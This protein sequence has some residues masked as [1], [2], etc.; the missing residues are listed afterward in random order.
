MDYTGIHMAKEAIQNATNMCV[1]TTNFVAMAN[2]LICANLGLTLNAGKIFRLAVMQEKPKDND[3]FKPYKLNIKE[4]GELINRDGDSLYKDLD[5]ITDELLYKK[6]LIRDI[7]DPESRWSKI[8]LCSRASFDKGDIYIVVNNELKPYLKNLEGFYS[9]Y[10]LDKIMPFS[11]RYGVDLYELIKVG[12]QND[13]LLLPED[14]REII[15]TMDALRIRTE[16][17]ELYPRSN[18]FKKRVIDP[19]VED[20]NAITCGLRIKSVEA[21]KKSRKVIAYKF[22]ITSWTAQNPMNDEIRKKVANKK[23]EIKEKKIRKHKEIKESY[24]Q[25]GL[26]EFI[27]LRG[28]G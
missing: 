10:Q 6:I 23:K 17:V 21:V 2:E 22:L 18:D 1:D 28:E 19:A 27:K 4:F 25:M 8:N 24:I 26:E 13:H 3:D 15:I 11:S 12:L 5:R 16:T 20:I 7:N 14:E 9:Q